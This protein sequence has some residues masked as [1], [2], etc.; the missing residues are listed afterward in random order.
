MNFRELF[1]PES[2]KDLA[3]A[4]AIPAAAVFI[5]AMLLPDAGQPA[6]E[7]AQEPQEIVG[8][9][10]PASEPERVWTWPL[11]VEDQPAAEEPAAADM[12]EEHAPHRRHRRH[13]RRG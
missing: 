11:A 9:F 3:I 13:G 7:P 1:D 2:A 5:L 4:L 10:M 8:R 6:Q 12:D